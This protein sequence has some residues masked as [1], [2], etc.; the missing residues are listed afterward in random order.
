[1]SDNHEQDAALE[2]ARTELTSAFKSYHRWHT[3]PMRPV[4]M[5]VGQVGDMIVE[6]NPT[7]AG[8]WF[9]TGRPSAGYVGAP[10]DIFAV[11][12]TPTE[13]IRALIDQT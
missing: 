11:A 5:V 13:L 4:G 9:G 7:P 1:M 8:T 2:A 6:M 3:L 12:A 10:Y